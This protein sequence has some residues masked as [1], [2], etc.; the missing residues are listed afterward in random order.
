MRQ[1]CGVSH[2][3]HRQ[4]L[5]CL[6]PLL[7]Q[8]DVKC[9]LEY[10]AVRLQQR[11]SRRPLGAAP[12]AAGGGTVA[13]AAAAAQL[14]TDDI[15]VPPQQLLLRLGIVVSTAGIAR[16]AAGPAAA[17]VGGLAAAQAHR[18]LKPLLR[19][20]AGTLGSGLGSLRQ[21][22]H[23]RAT[24]PA[25]AASALLLPRRVALAAATAA[26][27]ALPARQQQLAGERVRLMRVAAAAGRPASRIYLC[28]QVVALLLLLRASCCIL[29]RP[30]ETLLFRAP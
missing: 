12:A 18:A 28:W 10:S 8:L 27:P 29:A 22:G 6:L 19:E 1:E 13:A 21:L 4:A 15:H 20:L 2:T 9:S 11:A 23:S 3:A 14:L 26:A 30:R 25:G 24:R 16:A 5:F 17:A 7:L